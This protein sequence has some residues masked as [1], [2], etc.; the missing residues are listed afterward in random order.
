LE[1]LLQVDVCSTYWG[2][3]GVSFPFARML[4]MLLMMRTMRKPFS[5]LAEPDPLPLLK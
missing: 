5:L 2:A 1:H 3:L 4:L